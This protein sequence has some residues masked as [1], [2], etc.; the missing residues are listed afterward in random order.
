VRS[1]EQRLGP[2]P[3]NPNPANVEAQRFIDRVLRSRTSIGLQ[4]MNQD[5]IAGIGNVYRAELLFRA[6]LNPHTPGNLLTSEQL[7]ATWDD[8]VKLLKVGVAT[9]FMVTR[10]ELFKKRPKK[11]DRNFVYKRE[12]LACRDCGVNIVIELMAAR[13][14]YWCPG[15]QK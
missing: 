12:G 15:C 2:D 9:G 13:K 6:G 8:S 3:L 4:L 14:L 5:V 10:D 1:V 11:A 7:Q